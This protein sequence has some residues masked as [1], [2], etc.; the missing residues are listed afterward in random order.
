MV[1]LAGNIASCPD[2]CAVGAGAFGGIAG[3]LS[4]L[5]TVVGAEPGVTPA[6]PAA[7][8]AAASAF[9]RRVSMPFLAA[10][11]R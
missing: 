2:P 8:A 9:R 4:G 3:A 7:A 10:S 5:G 1:V 11:E 6:A